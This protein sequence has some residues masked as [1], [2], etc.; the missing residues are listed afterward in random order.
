ME[1]FV[2][3][4]LSYSLGGNFDPNDVD[5]ERVVLLG[6]IFDRSPSTIPYASDFNRA[7]QE[8]LQE[9]QKSHIVDELFFQI[10]SFAS[11]VTVDS[12]WAPVS[13]CDTNR[14]FFSS[15]RN[16]LTAGYDA[17][18]IGLESMLSYGAALEKQAVDVR[19]N[20]CI[21]TDG[22]FNDGIDQTGK[23]VRTILDKIRSD[24]NLYGKFTIFLYGVG[25]D[26]DFEKACDN[27]TIDR[28]AILRVGASGADFKK[29][30]SSVS[31]SVSKSSS[32][33]AV[34]NF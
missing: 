27:M 5:Q 15:S 30:L 14:T 21:F 33:S 11:D 19:Y 22:D 1:N 4:P 12:G 28:T 8:F 26:V 10:V 24:E 31:Q 2:A 16:G 9:E 3:P 6:L 25:K 32:G 20:L 34:P 29:M 17:V 13:G 7:T 18:K 23:S